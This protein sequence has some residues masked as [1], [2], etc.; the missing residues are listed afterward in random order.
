MND[1]KPKDLYNPFAAQ[2]RLIVA[3]LPC[4]WRAW[5]R[6][7]EEIFRLFCHSDCVA[8]AAEYLEAQDALLHSKIADLTNIASIRNA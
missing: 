1:I 4:D 6:F 2:R 8:G 7:C 3:R 5:T